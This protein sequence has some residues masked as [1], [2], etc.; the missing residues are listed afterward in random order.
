M[1][2]M[3]IGCA[4]VVGCSAMGAS[5]GGGP[6]GA[7]NQRECWA[8]LNGLRAGIKQIQW[9]HEGAAVATYRLARIPG[10][11][12]GW[13]LGGI[14]WVANIY[15]WDKYGNP[16]ESGLGGG[17]PI[18]IPSDFALGGRLETEMCV[19]LAPP[20]RAAFVSIALSR[21]GLFTPRHSLRPAPRPTTMRADPG[22]GGSQP[23]RRG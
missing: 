13:S 16:V 6:V 12:V 4:L 10:K 9:T 5:C 18:F 8:E 11:T 2:K 7:T 15:Y 23:G 14:H 22:K 1:V 20:R 21:T 3:K 17:F 19:L